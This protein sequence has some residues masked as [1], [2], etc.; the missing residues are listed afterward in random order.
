MERN[1]LQK[2]TNHNLSRWCLQHV[3]VEVPLVLTDQRK[4]KGFKKGEAGQASEVTADA[5]YRWTADSLPPEQDRHEE[6]APLLKGH[7]A[8]SVTDSPQ[9]P[10]AALREPLTWTL[11]FAIHG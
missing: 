9:T 1:L 2:I 5:R 3:N 4:P 7:R 11:T 10:T 6:G 8:C